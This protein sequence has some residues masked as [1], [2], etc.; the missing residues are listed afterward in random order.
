MVFDMTL[1][2]HKKVRKF[3]TKKLKFAKTC[4]NFAISVLK[5][6]HFFC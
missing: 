6:V 4:Q 5:K 1:K 2:V 3:A